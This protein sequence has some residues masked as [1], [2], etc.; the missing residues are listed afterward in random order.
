MLPAEMKVLKILSDANG[1]PVPAEALQEK[2]GFADAELQIVVSSLESKD[3]IC[4]LGGGEFDGK[5]LRF[6]LAHI[7][8]TG[9]AALLPHMEFA[10]QTVSA[11]D[12]W[13]I[14]H[15]LI[16]L[17]HTKAGEYTAVGEDPLVATGRAFRDVVLSREAK[18]G[19]KIPAWKQELINR[20]NAEKD[21]SA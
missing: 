17:V 20:A 16:D 15:E 10:N 7:K 21:G 9:S 4:A 19:A 2:T 6:S 8:R 12:R 13:Q 14:E 5:P 3:W 11:A 18:P 1:R